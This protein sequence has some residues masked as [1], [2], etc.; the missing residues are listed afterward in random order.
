MG[1]PQ[2]GKFALTC[3]VKRVTRVRFLLL[4]RENVGTLCGDTIMVA[5]PLFCP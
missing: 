2:V 3:T 5:L 1:K 4:L